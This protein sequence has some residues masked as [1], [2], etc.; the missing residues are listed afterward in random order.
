[1]EFMIHNVAH[2]PKT[3][4]QR[5]QAPSHPRHKQFILKTQ[6]RLIPNK[7]IEVSEKELF[8]NIEELRSLHR[9]GIVEVKTKSGQVVD[10]HALKLEPKLPDPPKPKFRPDSAQNDPPRGKSAVFTPDTTE[11]ISHETEAHAG[12]GMTP[13]A[14]AQ[15]DEDLKLPPLPDE[16]Q[17]LDEPQ[18]PQ[19]VASG[20]V[21]NEEMANAFDGEEPDLEHKE[22]PKKSGKS[23]RR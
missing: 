20:E 1:M 21:T 6:R 7:P 4:L 19:A 15:A 14:V 13:E 10:I 11:V 9:R 12:G 5:Y 22:T 8:E 16:L 3:R 2:H 23:R 17:H 18:P